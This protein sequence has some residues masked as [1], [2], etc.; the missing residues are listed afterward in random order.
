MSD[1]R[2]TPS[3]TARRH[4]DILTASIVVLISI[5]AFE[6]RP[7]DRVTIRGQ[8][9]LP[10]PFTC[11]FLATTGLPCPGCG[12]TRAMVHLAHGDLK[13]SWR[14]HWLGIPLGV[15]LILQTPY[16]LLALYRPRDRRISPRLQI[17]LGYGLLALALGRWLIDLRQELHF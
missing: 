14:R 12:L 11:P 17:V 6:V 2:S 13:S 5:A 16:R 10:V 4:R 1:V 15:V 3:A 9:W 8:P 7:D